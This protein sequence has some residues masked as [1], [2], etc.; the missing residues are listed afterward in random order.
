MMARGIFALCLLVLASTGCAKKPVM[1]ASLVDL[2]P[3]QRILVDQVLDACPGLANHAG[4]WELISTTLADGQ[5]QEVEIKM[6]DNLRT[7]PFDTYATAHVCSFLIGEDA[8]GSIGVAKSPC[9]N[10]CMGR[11]TDIPPTLYHRIK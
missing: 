11:K 7:M 1:N 3:K 8:P 6:A 10:A 2:N 5:R 4:D 9:V